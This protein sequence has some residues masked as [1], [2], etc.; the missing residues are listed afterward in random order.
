MRSNAYI[1]IH[2]YVHVAVII[3]A[4]ELLVCQ[5]FPP[6]MVLT[7][8]NRNLILMASSDANPVCPKTGSSGC[9][10]ATF[11]ADPPWQRSV[12]VGIREKTHKAHT[13]VRHKACSPPGATTDASS[14][15]FPVA[16][17]RHK[18]PS[19]KQHPPEISAGQYKFKEPPPSSKKRP[20]ATT[21]DPPP[22]KVKVGSL[23]HIQLQASSLGDIAHP[24]PKQNILSFKA[25][26]PLSMLM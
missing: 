24:P 17:M 22:I 11:K 10:K 8:H 6:L 13:P 16:S 2:M 23:P 9:T 12:A 19:L 15:F 3:L 26:P 7:L 18:Q 25:P 5:P 4:Q 1:Q 14:Q 20:F 21:L